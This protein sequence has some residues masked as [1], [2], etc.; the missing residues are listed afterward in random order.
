MVE[1]LKS[2]AY[3]LP[4]G[5]GGAGVLELGCIALKLACHADMALLYKN[6]HNLH[7][8]TPYEACW[9]RSLPEAVVDV[10]PLPFT[11]E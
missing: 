7:N 10:N 4:H 9:E 6:L 11:A 5:G 1:E 8:M 2:G 3:G